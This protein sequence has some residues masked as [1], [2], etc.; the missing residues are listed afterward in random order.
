MVRPIGALAGIHVPVTIAG[1][2]YHGRL[3]YGWGT[4]SSGRADFSKGWAEAT[5][6]TVIIDGI[7]Y[8]IELDHWSW[9]YSG[10]YSGWSVTTDG[11]SLDVDNPYVTE[12]S[13]ETTG[14]LTIYAHWKAVR[15]TPTTFTVVVQAD[16]PHGGTVTGGGTYSSGATCTITA[17]PNANDGY[18][19]VTPNGWTSSN[20]EHADTATHSFQ[21]TADVTWTAHFRTYRLLYATGGRLLCDS[22][23]RLLYNG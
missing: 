22:S 7:E 9:E 2:E 18:R 16:P 19:F 21:V 20:G 10:T 23:G 17:T 8:S 6:E 11:N 13:G 1:I 12:Q 14:T 15:P 3:R 5:N 4:D